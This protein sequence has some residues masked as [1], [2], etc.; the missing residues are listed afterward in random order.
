MKKKVLILI[1][2]LLLI[3]G[4]TIAQEDEDGVRIIFMHHSTGAGVMHDGNVREGLTELGY[5]FWDHDY[6]DEGLSDGDGNN[7]GYSW[8]VP[9]DN[10]DPDG[11]YNIFN[12]PVTSPPSNTLS[13]MLE[14]DVIIFKSCFPASAI[15]DDDMFDSYQE[16]YL[17]IRNVMDMY[18][19]KMFIAWTTAPLVPNE[20]NAEEAT[21]ARR[22]SEYLTSEEYIEGHPNVYVFD[23]FNLMADEDGFLRSDYRSDE[24]DSHPS[25]RA[26]RIA[27]PVLVDYIDQV[28]TNFV[29]GEA[30]PHPVIDVPETSD[31]DGDTAED[32]YQN[33]PGVVVANAGDMI[34]DFEGGDFGDYWW[35][36]TDESAKI[37]SFELVAP[38]YN[39]DYA[40]QL[41]FDAPLEQYLG[42]GKG[43]E[44]TVD[45]SA[46]S[47]VSFFWRSEQ[48]EM[49]I[50][51]VV[52]AGD[53]ESSTPFE[54]ELQTPGNEWRQE[55]IYWHELTKAEWM[56]ADG[57]GQ[58][59]ATLVVG[60]GLDIGSWEEK[61]SNVIW[62]DD[63][64]LME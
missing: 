29:P 7:L 25:E 30:V 53:M 47:G 20:T 24:W 34:E 33:A 21:R 50:R 5:Q 45:W 1:C 11:W 62:L 32:D 64:Q 19:E 28:I 43:F 61:L 51:F 38:G 59:D 23:F 44:S 49:P 39:G 58:F 9:G 15:Y 54:I 12:Q 40:M 42:V 4:G 31:D 37:G 26:N 63:L 27:G 36:Y 10:T 3:G 8:D 57:L 16:Y 52:F 13:H 55:F 48:V 46:S 17:S 60:V 35:H 41:S 2:V 18:P 14:Y 22:W 6:N 56:G